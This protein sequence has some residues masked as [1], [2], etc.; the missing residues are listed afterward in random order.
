MMESKSD[1]Q[2]TVLVTDNAVPVEGVNV[3]ITSDGGGTFLTNTGITDAN[4]SCIFVFTAPETTTDTAVNVTALAT[5]AGYDSVEKRATINV[6]PLIVPVEGLAG[7]PWLTIILILIPIIA[8]V[9]VA[10]LIKMKVLVISR[11]D[12][13][14]ED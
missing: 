14:G 11:G 12:T 6:A 3:T 7:L 2:I 4:G 9:V 5:K 8:V 13:E 1:S 10:V